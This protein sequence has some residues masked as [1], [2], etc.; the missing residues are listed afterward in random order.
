MAVMLMGMLWTVSTP[1]F[2][3]VTV[4]SSI[5]DC[6]PADAEYASAIMEA[7]TEVERIDSADVRRPATG[8]RILIFNLPPGRPVVAMTGSDNVL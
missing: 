7:A 6:A 1:R 5:A 4:I 2:D 8:V 3:A